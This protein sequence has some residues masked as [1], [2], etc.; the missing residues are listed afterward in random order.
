M[1]QRKHSYEHYFA[2]QPKSEV[3]LGLI[4]TH[5]RGLPFEFLTS[6]SVF[7]K[8]QVDKG[9]RLLIENMLLPKKSCILDLGC[10]YGAIGI[11][12]A[13]FNPGSHVIMTDI[14]KRAIHLAKENIE[15]NKVTNAEVK[16]GFLYEPVEE[17]TFNCILSNPPVSAGMATVKA[18][19]TRAPK[20]MAKKAMFQMVVRSKIGSKTLPSLFTA[21]FGNCNVLARESGYRALIGEKQ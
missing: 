2:A 20:V 17:T 14:N 19:I 18:I 8:R 1:T 11:A 15:R 5:L 3:R 7:S 4:R 12:A 9:T 6:S 16:H 13:T 21:T 10:G